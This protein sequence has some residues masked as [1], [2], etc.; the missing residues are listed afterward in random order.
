[1]PALLVTCTC[2][3]ATSAQ[4]LATALVHARLA[5]CVQ[6]LPGL[7][8]TYRWQ[9]QVESADEVLLLIKTWDDRLETLIATIR[10]RHPYELPEIMAVEAVG[11]LAP[12]LAWLY[13]E[14]RA[15]PGAPNENPE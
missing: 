11:G 14:T 9:G 2:P 15:P 8:S 6:Q 13:D 5:A 7:H 3:N 4:T 12:Y 1:M 10:S